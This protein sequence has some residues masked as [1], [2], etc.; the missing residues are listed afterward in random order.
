MSISENAGMQLPD[1]LY[2]QIV[3][4]RISSLIERYELQELE[5]FSDAGE[6]NTHLARLLA[7]QIFVKLQTLTSDIEKAKLANEILDSVGS[8]ERLV[9]G[10]G[11]KK[12][13]SLVA[14]RTTQGTKHL[15][16]RPSTPLSEM[17]LITNAAK[18]LN[19]GSELRL[20]L[21]SAD[22][23]DIIM[24]FIKKGGVRSIE[25]AL[26]KLRERNVPVRILTSVYLGA[27]DK[28][29]IDRLVEEFGAEVRIS[30]DTN[31]TR[32]HAKAWLIHRD[33][34]FS[35]AYVG[36]SN[37]SDPALGDGM[38][39]NVRLSQI[40]SPNLL[41]HFGIA[42]EGYWLGGEFKPYDSTKDA[43]K[44]EEALAR[45]NFKTSRE[46]FSTIFLKGFDIEPKQHQVKM[47]EDLS[48]EREVLDHHRN[49]VVA[50]TGTGKTVLAALDYKRLQ[51][52]LGLRPKLLF[53][54]H[55]K[56]ILQ[57]AH[58]TFAEVLQD[59]EFGELMVDGQ[60]PKAWNHVFASVQSLAAFDL[61]KLDA[62]KFDYIVIDEFHHASAPTY[63]AL[64]EH[65]K[66]RELVGLT[67]TP[68]RADGKRV[69]DEF[70]E[71]RIAS[72]LRLW[73]AMDLGL[74]APFQYFGI[75]EKTDFSSIDWSG[76][77]YDTK[78][79]SSKVT[80]NDIRDRL[81]MKQLEL[82]VDDLSTMRALFFC[83]DVEH[84]T[85]ITQLLNASR[86]KAELV[87]GATDSQAR[88]NSIT[89][90]KNGQLN[91]LVS[92][93]VFNE[94]VD[95]PELDTVVMLRPTESSVVFLQQLGR[96]LRKH[97]GKSSVTVLD[98]IGLHR[99]EFRMD[100]RFEAITGARGSNLKR[101]IEAGFPQLPGGI[102]VVLDEMAQA[103]VLE[104]IKSQVTNG[105][106][107]LKRVV[108]I[109]QVTDFATF[110][111]RTE[112][113]A[114]DVLEKS[115]WLE[116]LLDAGLAERDSVSEADI[117]LARSGSRLLGVNDKLRCDSYLKFLSGDLGNDLD[118]ANS[119]L[120]NMLFWQLMPDAK[121]PDGSDAISVDQAL[122][123]ILKQQA[124]I[125]ELISILTIQR[126][127]ALDLVTPISF[128]KS[129]LPVFAHGTYSRDEL[130]AAVGWA[131]FGG[132]F[133]LLKTRKSRGHQTG[134]EYLENLELDLFFVNLVKDEK[135]F[136]EST[137]YNDY[138][139]N[140]TTFVWQTQNKDDSTTKAGQRYIKQGETNH[141]VLI[142]VR[143]SSDGGPFK[144]VG[145]VDYVSHSG[146]KPMSIQW[147]LREPMDVELLKISAAVRVA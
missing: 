20:E 89:K 45:A 82:N 92:V 6:T 88:T 2:D 14:R 142:A 13:S 11:L 108:E 19:L 91:A 98:F 18:D 10:E 124:G 23:V 76:G 143:E 30:F 137:R 125:K 102:S 5:S 69:Q 37:L 9:A 109:E 33:T 41:R 136:S 29:A 107:S 85:Y 25:S 67:A 123:D 65:F 8:Q 26:K 51:A 53:V 133:G 117:K 132:E 72:E 81:L 49:L 12:L 16:K 59:N 57:Q 24:A 58:R 36:S 71:G 7:E 55:R 27:S 147:S 74:L 114:S 130:L 15:E 84:A 21:E 48:R 22:R 43:E 68:E 144:L 100:K 54:A 40:A 17:S 104:N 3:T 83:V 110:L 75:G 44:L 106:A 31:S 118:S 86:I 77:R 56:E 66:P 138:A 116:L 4:E 46:E 97:P 60:A 62:D 93:D 95:I 140:S 113:Q 87:V 1:G 34:G 61:L 63:R 94:G 120:K 99:K 145:L 112:R 126:A 111:R 64:I 50:A 139:L 119:R 141:D 70:F 47:L 115:S 42:F 101:Q 78:E 52:N 80:R 79:L 103:S 28:A 129:Q 135:K 122:R 127:E 128:K 121:L 39:W 32:L 146:A 38:E 105:L 35:T 90:L 131:G 134:V 96:G 73:D